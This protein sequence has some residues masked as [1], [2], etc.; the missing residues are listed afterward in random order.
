MHQVQRLEG[1]FQEKSHIE[2]QEKRIKQKQHKPYL[3]MQFAQRR[4]IHF[5]TLIGQQQS[6]QHQPWKLPLKHR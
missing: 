6:Q 5:F 4:I 1:L 3:Q 2:S